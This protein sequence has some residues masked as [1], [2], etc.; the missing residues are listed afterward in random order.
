MVFLA[1]G[2]WELV[3]FTLIFL[4]SVIGPAALPNNHLNLLWLAAPALV[5]AAMFFSSAY[6]PDNL[7]AHLQIL[8]IGAAITVLSDTAVV[9]TGSYDWSSSVPGLVGPRVLLAFALA[10]LVVDLLVVSYLLVFR[11]RTLRESPELDQSRKTEQ[12]E[13]RP[14]YDPTDVR[15]D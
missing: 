8:R 6:H 12:D 3:R 2:V 5:L 15:S 7:R 10:V 11:D 13:H 4:S 9:V 1:A 14:E